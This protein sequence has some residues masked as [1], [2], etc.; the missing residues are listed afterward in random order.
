MLHQS[1]DTRS[2]P[3]GWFFLNCG[4]PDTAY[5]YH[6]GWVKP[7]RV[8]THHVMCE[9][10][11]AENRNR[12]GEK[13]KISSSDGTAIIPGMDRNYRDF[14]PKYQFRAMRDYLERHGL[15]DSSG[16]RHDS[17]PIKPFQAKATEE[18]D[19]AIEPPEET[20]NS[21]PSPGCSL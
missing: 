11:D 8:A 7:I 1:T 12:V 20:E 10:V 9:I 3:D 5:R 13:I 15:A 17:I 16:P 19:V 4:H 18:A 2:I 6:I 21:P 14:I